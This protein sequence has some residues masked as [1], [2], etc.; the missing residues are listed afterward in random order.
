MKSGILILVVLLS[1]S[2]SI[3]YQTPEPKERIRLTFNK[4]KQSL[5]SCI[6]DLLQRA[7]AITNTDT[8]TLLAFKAAFLRSRLKYKEIEF[9]AEYYAYYLHINKP[10]VPEVNEND[11]EVEKPQGFGVVENILYTGDVY[12]SLKEL[13]QETYLLQLNVQA[14]YRVNNDLLSANDS[15]LFEVMRAE[16]IRIIALGI[17]GYDT[18]ESKTCILESAMALQAVR[19][20]VSEYY[21]NLRKEIKEKLEIKFYGGIHY[22]SSNI[23]FNSFNMLEFITEYANP[24]SALLLEAQKDLKI[25]VQT[26]TY[27]LVNYNAPIIFDKAAFSRY[28]LTVI[29]EGENPKAIAELGKVLFFDPVLSGNK[30]RACASCHNPDELFTDGLERSIAFNFEGVVN[31]NAPTL[32]NVSLQPLFFHDVRAKSLEDQAGIVI[33]NKIELGGNLKE[34]AAVL[35]NSND[36]KKLFSKAFGENDTLITVDRIKKS[37]AGFERSLIRFNSPFDQYIAG[38]K[39][40]LTASQVKGFN[41]FMGKAQCGT[42]H[43]IPLFNGLVPPEYKKMELEVLGTTA[44]NNFKNPKLDEDKGR[45][46]V[47]K[48]PIRNR[49][50][51]TP[52][53]RN[54]EYTAPYMHN[55]AFKSLEEVME[56]YN[57]GGG[58]GLGLDVPNQTLPSKPLNLTQEEIKDVIAFMRSLSDSGPYIKKPKHLPEINGVTRKLGGEY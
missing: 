4:K 33:E 29:K 51:K 27:N 36:Y 8:T 11:A 17:S 9:L 40:K 50:F 25:P 18:P 30:K 26:S 43:F 21:P 56:F 42:C 10:A 19:N 37:I 14:L 57:K 39:T 53:V 15:Q 2:S 45:F 5:D 55:G 31:R 6:I 44:D 20:A 24:I 16:V 12:Q 48:L 35:N 38:D 22:L 32:V 47:I 54:A 3:L 52:S 7:D 28:Y 13:K 46:E 1:L 34:I 49:A 58:Q 41:L 23:D